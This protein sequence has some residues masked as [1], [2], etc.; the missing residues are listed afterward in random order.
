VLA[1]D[2]GFQKTDKD[3]KFDEITYSHLIKETKEAIVKCL[4]EKK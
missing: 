1:I 3:V 4:N 2:Y